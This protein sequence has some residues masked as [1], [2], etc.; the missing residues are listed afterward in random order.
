MTSKGK[1]DH[2]YKQ[3]YRETV[4]GIIRSLAHHLP[5]K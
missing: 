1:N 5:G 4:T 2:F 3:Q